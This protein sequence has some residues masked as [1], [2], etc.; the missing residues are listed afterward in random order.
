MW[1]RPTKTSRP[2]SSRCLAAKHSWL[3][4]FRS[5]AEW[6]CKRQGV[7]K[8]QPFCSAFR[9]HAF[10]LRS[11][12][13]EDEDGTFQKGKTLRGDE[14]HPCRGAQDEVLVASLPRLGEPPT[15][16]PGEAAVRLH[17]MSERA[18]HCRSEALVSKSSRHFGKASILLIRLM[19][20]CRKDMTRHDKAFDIQRDPTSTKR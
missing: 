1:A 2:K 17:R 11:S 12:F 16:A 6:N 8:C 3:W 9:P 15:G 20:S 13:C 5:T 18:L 7:R 4:T 19:G 10:I 14:G